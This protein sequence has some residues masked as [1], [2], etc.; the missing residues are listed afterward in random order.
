MAAATQDLDTPF[1]DRGPV[2]KVPVNGG[3]II[4]AGT[5][6]CLDATGYAIP[7]ADTAGISPVIGRAAHKADA[8]GLADGAITVEVEE[9]IFRW[10][11]NSVTQAHV[12]VTSVT[13][14]DDNTVG[15]AAATTND[16]VAG[17]VWELAGDGDPSGTV[18]LKVPA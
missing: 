4:Y 2:R 17:K 6:V 1:K 7:A 18:W 5:M 16:I 9:G 12:A 14:V 15:L 8:T 3:S 11:A 13:I 10:N